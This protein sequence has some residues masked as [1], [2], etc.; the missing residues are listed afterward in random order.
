[1]LRLVRGAHLRHFL[2]NYRPPRRAAA[3]E[4]VKVAPICVIKIP[5]ALPNLES[6][7][8]DS[9]FI[10]LLCRGERGHR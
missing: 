4:N 3:T 8:I 7:Y 6:G 1:M 9:A 10:R 2:K 5:R